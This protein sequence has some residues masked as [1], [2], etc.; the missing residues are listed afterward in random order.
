MTATSPARRA[1]EAAGVLV[2]GEETGGRLAVVELRER[3]GAGPPRHIHGREDEVVYV[4]AGRVTFEVDGATVDAGAGTCL[5]LPRGREHTYR[6]RSGTARL[7]V[8]AV[9]AGLEGYFRDLGRPAES[10]AAGAIERL[11]TVAARHGVTITGP[12]R[13]RGRAMKRERSPPR[14]DPAKPTG[15][16]T[17]AETLVK[18]RKGTAG[19]G[20]GGAR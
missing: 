1:D 6:V 3:R 9:P 7:L 15:I 4:L 19:P 2:A 14:G 16:P 20:R 13:R 10:G 12:A 8:I 18:G 17:D 11:V 5:V